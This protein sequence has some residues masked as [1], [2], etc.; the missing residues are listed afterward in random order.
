MEPS[1]SYPRGGSIGI[2]QQARRARW[3]FFSGSEREKD[4]RM[5][6]QG[7]WSTT[8]N[9]AASLTPNI[10]EGIT[11]LAS[12]TGVAIRLLKQFV[13]GREIAGGLWERLAWGLLA[14]AWPPLLAFVGIVKKLTR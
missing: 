1:R 2:G 11:S 10:G 6:R 9:I 14:A 5:E 8:S 12:R 4:K 7:N 13:I 3:D